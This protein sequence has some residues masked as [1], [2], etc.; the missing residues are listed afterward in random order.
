MKKKP[1]KVRGVIDSDVKYTEFYSKL[2]LK[3]KSTRKLHKAIKYQNIFKTECFI[4]NKHAH[5][6]RINE[7]NRISDIKTI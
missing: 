7:E 3:E 5:L 6:L 4:Y 1:T 2:L